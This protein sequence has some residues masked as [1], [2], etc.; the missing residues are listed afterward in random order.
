[1]VI[2][3]NEG[4]VR[5]LE[6]VRQVVAGTQA[7]EFRRAE[8]DEGRYAWI[9]SVLRR[10][11][12]RQLPR[13]ERGPVLAYVQHLSGYSRAQVTRLVS[14]WT[15]G[16]RLV[17]EY[18][19]PEHAFARRY[20][21]ADVA[22]LA[23]V[24]RAMDTLSGPATACVLRRQRDVFGDTRFQRLGS[25][26]VGHL[27]NLRNSAPYRAQRVVLTKTRPTQAATIG[28]RKAPA[29][30][31][32]PG[33]IRI[34]SVHQGDLD[35]TKGLYHINAVDCVTQW[36]VVASV[37]TISEV[38]LLPVIEQM[39]AQ[40]PFEILGFHADNGSEYVN[41][42][43][44]RMLD[45]LRIEFTR[46]RP[47]RS[48]DNGL[49]E[50]KNG[51]VVR[52][53]FG[54]EHIHQRHA[55]RF[56]IFC[57]EFLNPFLNFHR[58]CLFATELADPKKPGRIKRVYRPKDAMT[59]LDKLASLPRAAT[60]L[61]EGVTFD[62]LHALARALTDVQAAEELNEARLALFR[63]IPARTG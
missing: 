21:A 60:F 16:K 37:R 56:N 28:V 12:Y 24:D 25:I 45:K 47:R 46:S 3:M 22:L 40:F 39:L 52:K 23:E 57:Q 17:K 49:V 63:R 31:G 29:P 38:H 5:T 13:S 18:R 20:T 61:R 50:T 6:Q 15:V 7:L 30:E 42:Q 51:A 35:G 62:D 26:S 58:P 4:Q 55:G 1:M 14:R 8:D 43:V 2:D 34:D 27:Y 19:A 32:R 54:Y 9:E 44:A 41:H 36:Q 10:F 59:P 33:F 53:L 48:N 11:D